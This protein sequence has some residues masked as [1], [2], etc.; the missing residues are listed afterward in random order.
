MIMKFSQ[1]IQD[2]ALGELQST[3]MVEVGEFQIN[4]KFLP[5]VISVINRSLEHFYSVFPLSEKQILIQL[6]NGISHYYLDRRYAYSNQES[7]SVKY[8]IDTHLNPFNNDVLQIIEV[9]TI[10]GRSL[11]INDIH[12]NFG[13]LTPQPNCIH[14][15]YDLGVKQ[16]SVVY[17][18]SHQVIPLSEPATSNMEI[19]IP[20]AMHSAFMAYVACLVLQNMGGNKLNESNAFFAKYQTQMEMLKQQ[21]IGTKTQTG[22]NIKPYI[23]EWI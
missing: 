19:E 10:D 7:D 22:T 13:V 14:V 9:S 8:I 21:G 1:L 23:R 12:S 18:A 4:A 15:P 20:I 6:R 11:A 16:L 3:P 5:K 2:L 17:Q